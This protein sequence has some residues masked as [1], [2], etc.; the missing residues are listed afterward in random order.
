MFRFAETIDIF[1]MI[2]GTIGSLGVGAC[3]PVTY[4][5]GVYFNNA[6][7]ENDIDRKKEIGFDYLM[8]AI[9]TAL[10][11]FTFSWLMNSLWIIT[12]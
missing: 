9:Y 5:I 3:G 10:A 2:L 6:F 11:A 12:G 1:M 8:Y 4:Y 7:I